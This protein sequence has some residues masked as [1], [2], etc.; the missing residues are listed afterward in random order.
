MAG[1]P[2]LAVSVSAMPPAAGPMARSTEETLTLD[3]DFS[4]LDKND[5]YFC[6][7]CQLI[8]SRFKR[9]PKLG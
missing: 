5:V 3:S 8:S 9:F 1:S 2:Q 4:L 7:C 6:H